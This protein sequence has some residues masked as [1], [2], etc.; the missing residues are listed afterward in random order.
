MSDEIFYIYL[1]TA[2]PAIGLL[3]LYLIIKY[4]IVKKAKIKKAQDEINFTQK[5]YDDLKVISNKH[6]EEFEITE[7]GLVNESNV[8]N[9]N[10]YLNSTEVI[11]F[12]KKVNTIQSK[13][14]NLESLKQ[15]NG[16]RNMARK[17]KVS[18]I[19]LMGGL[20]GVLATNPRKALGDEIDK[21]NLE[22]WN[23]I[24]I[25]PHATHNLLVS[26]LQVILL[27]LTLGLF[28]WG[29]GYLVLFEK[30]E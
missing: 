11:E 30:E 5:K 23:A 1:L 13:Q 7:F 16:E 14:K 27:I 17:N 15:A 24:F 9:I 19:P 21:K 4:S 3:L 20:I 6:E 29:G 8:I 18:R 26:L 28:T 25:S 12:I 10:E 22:G 2:G